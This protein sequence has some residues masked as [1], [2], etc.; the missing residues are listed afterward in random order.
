MA[1]RRL[2]IDEDLGAD[3]V[4]DLEV[5]LQPDLEPLE[6]GRV[7]RDLKRYNLILAT[8]E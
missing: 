8:K 1:L 6:A 3:P 4:A 5:R 7:I 2:E